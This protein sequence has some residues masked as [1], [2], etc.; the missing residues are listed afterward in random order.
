MVLFPYRD[1]LQQSYHLSVTSWTQ[2]LPV[3][4]ATAQKT[5]TDHGHTSSAEQWA[6]WI[7]NCD[8]DITTS[9]TSPYT[10]SVAGSMEWDPRFFLGK[11]G[12]QC[13]QR[14]GVKHSD[15]VYLE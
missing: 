11:V 3:N 5:S 14:Y 1:L 2:A 6:N 13:V 10:P 12:T 7:P 4:V 15:Y 8:Y 9:F